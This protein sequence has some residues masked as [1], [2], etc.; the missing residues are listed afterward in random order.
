MKRK[1]TVLPFVFLFSLISFGQEKTTKYYSSNWKD[2]KKNKGMYVREIIK[3][4]DSLYYVQDYM[5]EGMTLEMRGYYK[6]I[7]PLIEDGPIEYFDRQGNQIMQGKYC[8]GELCG[9]WIV[10]NYIG[11]IKY[12][13]LDYN[14]N[15]FYFVPQEND[16]I[17]NVKEI[18]TDTKLEMKQP[19]FPGGDLELRKYIANNIVIP[20]S[21]IRYHK[22]GIVY[23]QFVV[24]EEGRIENALV[25]QSNYKDYDKESVRVVRNMPIWVPGEQ[26]GKKVKVS[27]TIPITFNVW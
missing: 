20:Y 8:N 27:F 5:S 7:S 15:N 1:L 17:K 18:S 12:A 24:N 16:S 14:F 4:K 21:G 2:L 19:E 6:S 23:V 10:N 11:G 9:K 26:D 3:V 13:E 22:S 25:V